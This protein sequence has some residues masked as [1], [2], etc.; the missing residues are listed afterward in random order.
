[1]SGRFSFSHQRL[2]GCVGILQDALDRTL[3]PHPDL[4]NFEVPPGADLWIR[5]DPWIQGSTF[6]WFFS[7]KEFTLID[8]FSD[9]FGVG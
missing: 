6:G 7:V 4:H 5:M 9:I 2:V 8:N 1:M 3:G